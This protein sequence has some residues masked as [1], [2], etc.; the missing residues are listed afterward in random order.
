[1]ILS[2]QI[3]ES[4][5][6]GMSLIPR[7]YP[8]FPSPWKKGFGEGLFDINKFFENL[9]EEFGLAMTHPSGLSVSSDDKNI[10]VEAHVPGLT[11]KDVE[12]SLDSEGVL[13]IKGEKKEEEKDKV[14]RYYRKASHTFSYCLPLWEEVDQKVEPEA[15][16]KDGIMKLTFAKKKE[17]R[18]ESKKIKVKEEK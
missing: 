7:W 2:K 9:E 13:W 12:V 1:M 14:K 6:V 5:E 8:K 4:K 10:Y 15:T 11:A 16:C 3:L 18:I 17:K